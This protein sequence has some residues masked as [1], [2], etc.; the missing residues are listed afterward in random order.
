MCWG[1]LAFCR[2]VQE[3][4]VRGS[5]PH[6]ALEKQMWILPEY[7]AYLVPLCNFDEP[8]PQLHKA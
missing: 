8:F 4:G 6:E 5:E 7:E 1:V 2:S 3:F